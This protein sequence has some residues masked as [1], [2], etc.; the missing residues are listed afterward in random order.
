MAR[1]ARKRAIARSEAWLVGGADV[2]GFRG[3]VR[4]G[5]VVSVEARVRRVRRNRWGRRRGPCLR[6]PG[7]R[8]VR[9]RLHIRLCR[10]LRW[11]AG[12]RTTD[13]KHVP[14]EWN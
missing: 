12:E 8:H 11:V 2:S 1:H 6:K 5:A 3:P 10:G 9:P 7:R 14:G 4:D 13:V